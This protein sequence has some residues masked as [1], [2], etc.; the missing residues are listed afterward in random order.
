MIFVDGCVPRSVADR[1]KEARP[2][3][4][5]KLDVFARDTKD[6][7]WL[8]ETGR[9]GWLVMTRDK[10]I[11]SRPGERRAIMESGAGC[12]I[13]SYRKA[14]KKEE[15]AEMVLSFLEDMEGLFEKTPRP[16]IY[17]VNRGGDFKQYELRP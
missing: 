11:K 10:K 4:I 3:T 7:V 12:F 1:V 17:T 5:W 8:R 9:Q 2:E 6:P 13:L 16:F 14:L 15:I